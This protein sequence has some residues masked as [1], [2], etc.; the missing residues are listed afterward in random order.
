[1][2]EEEEL[3]EERSGTTY[4]DK[5]DARSRVHLWY[6]DTV[7]GTVQAESETSCVL[8]WWDKDRQ[9]GKPPRY[10]NRNYLVPF[11]RELKA[12]EPSGNFKE[13]RRRYKGAV[14]SRQFGDLD[15]EWLGKAVQLDPTFP[16]RLILSG[17]SDDPEY[18]FVVL[19][20]NGD[21]CIISE[22]DFWYSTW[23]D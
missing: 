14:S 12:Y 15:R 18:P 16:E 10:A 19:R 20:P 11:G 9:A 3:A 5:I 2:E 8:V 23:V 1:M 4:S 21:V 6:D 7:C 13:E 17:I 22:V